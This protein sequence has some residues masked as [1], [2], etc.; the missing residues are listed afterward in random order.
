[1]MIMI[2]IIMMMVMI[3]I[4]NDNDY[5]EQKM[6]ETNMHTDVTPK[7]FIMGNELTISDSYH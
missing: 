6:K 4:C 2:K 5:L 7:G 3:N 1:M